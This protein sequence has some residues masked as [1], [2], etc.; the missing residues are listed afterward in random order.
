MNASLL[1]ADIHRLEGLWEAKK[2]D[3]AESER[4]LSEA[5]AHHAAWRQAHQILREE[6]AKLQAKVENDLSHL[7]TRALQAVLPFPYDAAR[8]AMEVRRNQPELEVWLE[9]GGRR[10]DPMT[11]TGGGVVDI[12]AL[13]LRLCL[14]AL[15]RNC[16]S[17]I[18]L[19]EPMRFIS[20][21][22]LPRAWALVENLAEE[23]SLLLLIVTHE[24]EI[25]QQ[26]TT[27]IEIPSKKGEV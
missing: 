6:G 20:K 11:E 25:L 14:W 7:L 8:V 21:G 12:I 18:L 15:S 26:T 2:Q 22:L 16:G 10:I 27:R 1:L 24:K 13:C 4:A 17:L 23:L 9:R 3:A 5:R 19:D